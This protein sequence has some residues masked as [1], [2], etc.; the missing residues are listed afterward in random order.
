[1][2][3][4]NNS[5]DFSPGFW[6]NISRSKTTE[7]HINH[8][9]ERPDGRPSAGKNSTL[10]T[11]LSPG[12]PEPVIPP[13]LGSNQKRTAACGR[14]AVIRITR[15]TTRLMDD[16]NLAESYKWLRDWLCYCGIIIGDGPG[17]IQAEYRQEKVAHKKDA[18][19]IVFVEYVEKEVI[20]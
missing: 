9:K 3:D 6:Q 18:G 4:V 12:Q 7:N 13:T 1:M 8:M 16:D 10:V 17:Q 5:F 2:N 15:R 14:C 11:G 20:P 19:T